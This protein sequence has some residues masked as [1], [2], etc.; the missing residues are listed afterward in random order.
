MTVKQKAK[1][2]AK[3]LRMERPDYFYLKE[4]FRHLRTELKVVV[5]Q[6]PKKLPYVPSEEEINNY[7]DLVWNAQNVAHIVLIKTL[8]YTG[9][10]VGELIKVKLEDVNLRQ[11]QIKINDGKGHKDR[12]VPFPKGFREVLVA[13]IKSC[14][15][16]QAIYLFESIRKG[17]YTDR[18]IR[19]ILLQ[20]TKLA[21]MDHTITPHKLRH[22]LF[23]WMKRQGIDDALIQ[24]YSG[25]ES[26]K[27]LE[28]YSK[29][30]ITDA[31]NSYNKAI[32]DFP[33]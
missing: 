31:Q 7:Y 1:Q 33:I 29:L 8:L 5:Q 27:S 32:H 10:R 24:P 13:Y 19:K 25:H 9:I 3:L 14:K 30:S 22:F 11:C 2:V 17:P 26:R 28:I 6:K 23:T 20:Y 16:K 18:G 4:L 21:N 15:E 12:V